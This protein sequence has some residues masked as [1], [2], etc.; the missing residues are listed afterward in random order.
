MA[1]GIVVGQL[2]TNDSAKPAAEAT[3]SIATSLM[4]SIATTVIVVGVLFADRRLARLADRLRPRQ[5]QGDRAGP[6][7]PR[8]PTSTR[9][10]AIVVCIYFLS[11]PTQNLRSFLTTLIIAGMA[12]FGIHELRK[13]TGDG[14]PRRQLRRRLRPHQGPRGRRRQGRQPRRASG[15]T[16]PAG[17]APAERR[18]ADLGGAD[19]RRRRQARTTPASP[20]SSAWPTLHEKGVLTDEEFAAEKAR[21]LGNGAA[22]PS[23]KP[24]SGIEPETSCITKQVLYQ[25]S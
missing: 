2:V 22:T 5:P 11:A 17:D 16:A 4:T 25:L 9:G 24:A 14:V 1:G 23:A 15:E 21:V 12:A 13:Q 10:L 3:W 18:D 8:R 6:A 19:R 7:R 20:A